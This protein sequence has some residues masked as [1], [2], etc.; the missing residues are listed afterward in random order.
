MLDREV[1]VL[2]TKLDILIED[3]Q[4][5]KT[6]QA[7]VNKEM[8]KHASEENVVQSKILT[9]LKWHSTIGAGVIG[10]TAYMFI[11]GMMIGS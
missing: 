11:H 1:I 2:E 7:S 3:F 9:T 8:T 4:R 10:A 5:F 6:E